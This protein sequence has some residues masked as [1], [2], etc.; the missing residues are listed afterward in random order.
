MTSTKIKRGWWLH[1]RCTPGITSPHGFCGRH[2]IRC[3]NEDVI[4][5]YR[6]LEQ[7]HLALGYVPKA[8]APTGTKR[9][10]PSGIGGKTCQKN[11]YNCSLH[12][13]CIAIDVEYSRNKYPKGLSRPIAWSQIKN[14]TVYTPA[15]VEGIEAILNVQGEPIFKWLGLTLG[16]TMHWE[17]DV[18]PE[19]MTIDYDTVPDGVPPTT[20]E[21][22]TT[23]DDMLIKKGHPV[24]ATVLKI[25]QGLIKWD[26]DALPRFGADG[27]FGSETE[28][29]IRQYQT[30]KE[31][32]VTG[33][34][35]SET[36]FL[37]YL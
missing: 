31:L 36:A 27:D 2:P 16:D 8:G 30:E 34:V 33:I 9:S 25:Q 15:I 28:S 18:P 35:D 20:P 29:W 37:L 32:P 23:E 21:P 19:R 17:I 7:A 22:P 5:A 3:A 14:Y 26:P 13:Y 4:E 24:E 6:V 11:G 12:N 10:C 1:Y